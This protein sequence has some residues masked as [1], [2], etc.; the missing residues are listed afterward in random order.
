MMNYTF[1][2]LSPQY[3]HFGNGVSKKIGGV[4]KTDMNIQRAVIFCDKFIHESGMLSEIEAS[5]KGA[6]ISYNIWSDVEPSPSHSNVMKATQFLKDNNAEVVIAVG[7]GSSLDVAKVARSMM[8]SPPPI[9]QYVDNPGKTKKCPIPQVSVPTTAGTGAEVTAGGVVADDVTH[10]KGIVKGPTQLATYAF[11]DPELTLS[12]P[13]KITAATGMDALTHSIEGVSSQNRNPVADLYHYEA[14]RLIAGNLR[15]AYADG[16]DI[17]ARYNMSLGAMLAGIGLAASSAGAAHGFAYPLEG[18]YRVSH[19]EANA[20]VLPAV[21]RHNAPAVAP[22]FRKVAEAM[23]EQVCCLTDR[24]A[25]L[26]AVA[27]VEQLSKDIKIPR[28]KDLNI[29]EEDLEY[30]SQEIMKLKRP[31]GNN[32]SFITIDD[33]RN[34][35]RESL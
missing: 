6:S 26:R 34:I 23:G 5:L 9:S 27:A 22:I 17:Q 20:A 7:G 15:T 13:P 33:A 2:L 8:D 19:G 28:L 16:K 31:L 1:R 14:I 18:K 35:Y 21:M 30:L 25:A 12:L 11:V 24:E 4:L 29:K 3:I 10:I 32:T